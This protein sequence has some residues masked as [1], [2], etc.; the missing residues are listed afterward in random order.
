[1]K[2]KKSKIIIPAMGLIL[3][4][5]AASIS[6]SVAWFTAN[7]TAEINTGNFAVVKTDGNLGVALT[8]G[9]GTAVSSTTVSAKTGGE[10]PNEWEAKLGDISFN[11]ATKQLWNDN[12]GGAGASF[13][14]VGDDNDY[15]TL[16]ESGHPFVLSSS[17]H[18][19]HAFT[20][21]V[22]LTY[23]W[24]A[25][26]T[27]MNLFF[28]YAASEMTGDANPGDVGTN[29]QEGFRIAIIGARTVVWAGLQANEA[30]LTGVTANNTVGTYGDTLSNASFSYF[31]ADA[32]GLGTT[33]VAS[34]T[35]KGDYA[36][37]TDRLANQRARA[38]YLGALSYDS[39]APTSTS[40]DLYCVAWYEGTDTAVVDSS[41]LQAVASQ[42]NFY[43]CIN[44]TN[45]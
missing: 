36:K 16:T 11:P 39:E 7:R 8:E 31:S 30:I 40:I 43:T 25:D 42:I 4:S 2:N 26:H 13:V 27:D 20:W 22:T 38:D 3:L 9:V 29:T 17:D 6:G 1:M 10:A 33:A 41:E 44:G 37:A 32:F 15:Q 18:V 5:T 45:A 21:K 19:Y 24:G 14:Q 34:A 28:D 35:A 23:T 12:D